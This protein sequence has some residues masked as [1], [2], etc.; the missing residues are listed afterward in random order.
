MVKQF[1]VTCPKCG[2][3]FPCHYEELRHKPIDL[4]CPHC[5]HT[6]PQEESPHIEE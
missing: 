1:I 4:L 2:G 3:K 6:F 5:Q